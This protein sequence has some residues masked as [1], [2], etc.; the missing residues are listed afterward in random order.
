MM[1]HKKGYD[2]SL[3][4][5]ILGVVFI[6][7]AFVVGLK[8]HTALAS[9]S[10]IETCR[11]SVNTKSIAIK[12]GSFGTRVADPVDL[13]LD[14]HTTDL[15]VK[16]DGVENQ[17]GMPVAKFDEGRF[18]GKKYED[19]LKTVMADSMEDCWKMFGKGEIDPF[20][21]LDGNKHCV[22]C[23]EIIFDREAKEEMQK[24]HDKQTLDNFNRFL[25]ENIGSNR[26]TYAKFLYKIEGQE[27]AEDFSKD[28]QPLDISKQY[29]VIFYSARGNGVADAA[30][31]AGEIV[32]CPSQWIPI[33]NFLGP[34]RKIVEV[35]D[36]VNPDCLGAKL[37]G[38]AITAPT[39]ALIH[40]VGIAYMPIEK[41]SGACRRLD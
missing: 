18:E 22:Q 2:T 39:D 41:M 26:G 20:T 3:N 5:V 28:S 35:G 9:E 14:C 32:S 13:N 34:F 36:F 1:R 27:E 24:A 7:A 12:F 29:A 6:I 38:F 25:V 40:Q 10:D 17:D 33:K 30:A 37:I 4:N 16:K 23:Y 21:R 15:I 19:K 8:V 31:K 11:A